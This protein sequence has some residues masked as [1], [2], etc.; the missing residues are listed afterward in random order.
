MEKK[1]TRSEDLENARRWANE[2]LLNK[3]VYHNDIKDFIEFN[4]VGISHSIY[5]KTYDEKI[6]MIYSTISIIKKSTLCGIEKD[7]KGR[8]DIKAVYKFVSNWEYQGKE[9]FVYIIVRENRQ[10]KFYYDHG[11]IKKKP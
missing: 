11:I 5:A 1:S 3:K 10:G 9:Y 7:K 8:Q 6:E 2:N 4:R